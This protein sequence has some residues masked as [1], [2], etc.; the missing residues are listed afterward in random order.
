V[1]FTQINSVTEESRLETAAQLVSSRNW[2][3]T[4]E[5]ELTWHIAVETSTVS[6][7]HYSWILSKLPNNTTTWWKCFRC[8]SWCLAPTVP[9]P[10]LPMSRSRKPLAAAGWTGQRGCVRWWCSVASVVALPQCSPCWLWSVAV[11][12]RRRADTR[13]PRTPSEQQHK[14]MYRQ[15]SRRSAADWHRLQ[16][17][18]TA[19][20]RQRRSLADRLSATPTWCLPGNTSQDSVCSRRRSASTCLADTRL[21][22]HSFNITDYSTPPLY[23]INQH[24]LLPHIITPNQLHHRL[25]LALVFL[26]TEYSPNCHIKQSKQSAHKWCGGLDYCLAHCL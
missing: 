25:L 21:Q 1:V 11:A 3:I 16:P 10:R 24:R 18:H 7:K 23:H 9:R 15:L 26:F 5:A 20:I 13:K 19:N 14:R 17:S 2:I 4:E 6:N 12:D 22:Q 8:F